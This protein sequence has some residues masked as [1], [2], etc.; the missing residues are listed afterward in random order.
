MFYVPKN[1][2]IEAIQ[3]KGNLTND[4]EIINFIGEVE[5]E[6]WLWSGDGK[7]IWVN[8][9][10]DFDSYKLRVGD[11]IIKESVDG[12]HTISHLPDAVFRQRY[13]PDNP[14]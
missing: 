1:R 10:N 9:E 12:Y 6:R 5:R 7:S 8:Y 13:E 3:F 4:L 11:W 2:K 14:E